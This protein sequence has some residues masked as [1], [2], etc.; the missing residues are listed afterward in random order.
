MAQTCSLGN[1]LRRVVAV[2]LLRGVQLY[3]WGDEM[4]YRFL[5][6]NDLVR[7]GDERWD[8]EEFGWTRCQDNHMERFSR[9]YR[10]VGS[11]AARER[12]W[13]RPTEKRN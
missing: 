10:H 11:K 6:A 13:R 9:E 5:R 8:G 3:V 1:D 2:A 7:F 4:K 12:R